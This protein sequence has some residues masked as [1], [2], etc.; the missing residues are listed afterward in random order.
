M[1]TPIGDRV[2]SGLVEAMK[3][4]RREVAQTTVNYTCLWEGVYRMFGE[5]PPPGAKPD[6]DTLA[7]AEWMCALSDEKRRLVSRLC[8]GD[9]VPWAQQVVKENKGGA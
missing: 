1:S 3:L 5:D 4:T 2:F 7:V 6:I 8:A 9:L